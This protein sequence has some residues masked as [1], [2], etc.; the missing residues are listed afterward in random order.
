MTLLG[1][2]VGTTHLKAGVFEEDGRVLSL[3]SRPTRTRLAPAGYAYYDPQELWETVTEVI[4]TALAVG[5]A[6]VAAVGVASMAESGLL[7]DRHT[8]GARSAFLPWFDQAA[9]PHA[10]QLSRHGAAL[11]R[12]S[13]TGIRPSFKCSLAK[14]LWLREQGV[15]LGPDVVWLSAA[16]YV[17]YRLSGGLQTDYS[18]AGRTY[19]FRIDKKD[20]D[21]GWLDEWGLSPGLF[22]PARPAGEPVGG[23]RPELRSALRLL[24]GTPVAVT[25]HDHIC[26]AFAVGAVDPG[27]VF[28]SLGTAESLAGALDERRL[29]EK[30]FKS[31]L[32]YGCH[33]AHG[34]MYWLSGLSA[35]GGSIEWLRGVLG[36]PPLTYEGLEDLLQHASP[37]PSGIL[38]FPY[39]A[40]S[41]SPHSDPAVRGAFIG[42]SAIHGRADLLKAVL[43][44]TAYEIET[45]RRAAEQA[46]GLEIRQ[47]IAAGGGVRNQYW[48][49]IKADVSGC[50]YAALAMPEA[51]LLGAALVAGAG[52]GVYAGQA[53]ALAA[54][55][56]L[57][58]ETYLPDETRHTVY[59]RYFQQGYLALQEPLRSYYTKSPENT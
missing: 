9:A 8:G 3:A 2:D 54:A 41:G 48:L 19:A 52:C 28:D 34:R 6:P 40:G 20:W 58:T 36:D 37:E 42:L 26:A 7:V 43:E 23:V 46:A 1:I 24:P 32:S 25:G 39:L 50:R 53:Q 21:A 49:Q 11:E 31:G 44:G 51:T 57:E 15:T 35:A 16:D 10:G 4:R 27:Q 59:Q 38:Y 18:L 13:R 45:G 14:L 47:V 12:F 17:A 56:P 33:V 55:H 22:P 30:E 5:P 29:G